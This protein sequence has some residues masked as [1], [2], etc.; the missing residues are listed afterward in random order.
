[1]MPAD[2]R[3]SDSCTFDRCCFFQSVT[4]ENQ[5]LETSASELL[6]VQKKSSQ[7]FSELVFNVKLFDSFKKNKNLKAKVL[8]EKKAFP[9]EFHTF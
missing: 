4:V 3:L 7:L 9:E 1:M 2:A 8:A 5:K 6:V